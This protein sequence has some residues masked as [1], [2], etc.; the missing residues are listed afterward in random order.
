MGTL[1][2][3]LAALQSSKAIRYRWQWSDVD[4]ALSRAL[5]LAEELRTSGDHRTKRLA[6]E[7]LVL[8]GWL[9]AGG[10]MPRRWELG[11]AARGALTAP[12]ETWPAIERRSGDRRARAVAS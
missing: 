3:L 10:T 11:K 9:R 7:V 5:R 12:H 6:M 2:Q 4:G 1:R 8:D